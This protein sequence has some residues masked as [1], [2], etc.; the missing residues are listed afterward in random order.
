M[1]IFDRGW[2]NLKA[3]AND[4]NIVGQQDATLLGPT[5]CER[6]HTMSHKYMRTRN[7]PLHFHLKTQHVV[8]CCERL[9]TSANIAQQETTMLAQQCCVLLRAFARAFKP[10][11]WTRA[12]NN[13]RFFPNNWM[14]DGS[15]YCSS[16]RLPTP[17]G[18]Y[19][20]KVNFP[21]GLKGL[22]RQS[23]DYAKILS[24]LNPNNYC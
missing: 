5:C 6:L 20:P 12:K 15:S 23:R 19:Y 17:L 11:W 10:N 14:S 7:Q 3:R 4:S 9:H 16:S 22:M 2:K 24:P 1:A 8:T 13:A 21:F 18:F